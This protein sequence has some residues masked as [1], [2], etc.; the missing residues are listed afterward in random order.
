MALQAMT[1]WQCETMNITTDQ[2]KVSRLINAPAMVALVVVMISNLAAN[3]ALPWCLRS[4]Q[5]AFDQPLLP[6]CEHT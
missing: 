2:R 5:G 1:G 3:T 4:A 6:C